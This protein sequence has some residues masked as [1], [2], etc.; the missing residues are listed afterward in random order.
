M[1]LTYLGRAGIADRD[2]DGR[3]RAGNRSRSPPGPLVLGCQGRPSGLP[4][5]TRRNASAP[6]LTRPLPSLPLPFFPNHGQTIGSRD[7][8]PA[9]AHAPTDSRVSSPAMIRLPNPPTAAVSRPGRLRI[10]ASGARATIRGPLPRTEA[11]EGPTA[12]AAASA[13]PHG[14]PVRVCSTVF[15]MFP[16]PPY[17]D[18]GGSPLVQALRG[19]RPQAR[20]TATFRLCADGQPPPAHSTW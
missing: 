6:S 13:T 4:S 16:D 5:A 11:E 12:P 15:A 1:P 9:G 3:G 17:P 10:A 8:P 14:E 2:L 7:P 18:L 19:P 20:H